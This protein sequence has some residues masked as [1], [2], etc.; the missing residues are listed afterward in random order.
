MGF[1]SFR[2]H[3]DK[4]FRYGF[5]VPQLFTNITAAKIWTLR[6][7]NPLFGP[8]TL[9]STVPVPDFSAIIFVDAYGAKHPHQ[10]SMSL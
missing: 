5:L 2:R 7:V 4:L 3:R 10:K 6:V 8:I 1:Q 9:L